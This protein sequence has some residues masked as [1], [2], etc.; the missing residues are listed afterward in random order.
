[1]KIK[2]VTRK[3]YN[4]HKENKFDIL[5]C[6]LTNY[7]YALVAMSV[8]SMI[9]LGNQLGVIIAMGGYYAFLVVLLTRPAYKTFYGK[10]LFWLSATGGGISGYYL[11]NYIIQYL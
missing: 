1:M 7:F 11:S 10:F 3:V 5:T 2:F 6:L 9:S 8:P 4:F